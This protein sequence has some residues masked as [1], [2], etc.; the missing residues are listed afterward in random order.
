MTSRFVSETLDL[1]RLPAPE[2][3]Q[4]ASFEDIFAARLTRFKE[5][6]PDFDMDGLE[7]DPVVILEQVAAYRETLAYAAINDAARSLLLPYATGANL[8][9]LAAF[10]GVKR[11]VLREATNT[12]PAVL[13]SDADLRRRA[14]LAPEALP[15]AGLTGGGYRSLALLTAPE[16]KDVG[17][18]KRGAGRVDVV[19]LGRAGNGAV[20]S[21]VVNKVYAAFADDAA[22]QLTDVVSVRSAEIVSYAVN[23]RLVLPRGPDPALVRE[24]ARQSIE[25]YVTSRHRVGQPVFVQMIAAAASVGGVERV[26]LNGPVSDVLP[27]P[28]QAAYCTGITVTHEVVE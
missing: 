15:Y 14:Q 18:V 19:L 25:A 2:V 9:N 23:V 21:E 24:T 22:T 3:V 28:A 16:V 1:S 4:P 13:E 20:S 8:D 26:I 12:E 6:W 27:D 7:T 5:L 11:H 10:Y 17:T